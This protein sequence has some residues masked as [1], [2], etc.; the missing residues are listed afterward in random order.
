MANSYQAEIATYTFI[1][2]IDKIQ[3]ALLENADA[4]F[5]K[6]TERALYNELMSIDAKSIEKSYVYKEKY[7]HFLKW[8]NTESIA[9]KTELLS[10]FPKKSFSIIPLIIQ[11]NSTT[12]FLHEIAI[13]N[14]SLTLENFKIFRN[15]SEVKE[16]VKKAVVEDPLFAKKYF[17]S[18]NEIF[19]W[20]Q[21]IENDTI[22]TILY[23]NKQIGKN[24]KA[25]ALTDAIIEQK[26]TIEEAHEI[27]KTNNEQ[28]LKI[29]LESRAKT[30]PV[31]KFSLE[32]ELTFVALQY[33]RNFN[34]QHE[35]YNASQRFSALKTL[36]VFELYTLIVYSEE[37]IFTS[38]F[39]GVFLA[40]LSKMKTEKISGIELMEKIGYNR[41]RAFVKMC[42]G[43]GKLDDFL[44]TFKD[45]NSKNLFIVRLIN[46]IDEENDFLKEAVSLA[47]AFGSISNKKILEIFS[48]ELLKSYQESNNK[49]LY[50]LLISVFSEKAVLYKDSIL[51]IAQNYPV[52]EIN[53]LQNNTL[54]G[55]DSTHI[56]WHFFY[57]DEDGKMSFGSFLSHFKD[58]NW[59]IVFM[60]EY[61]IISSL[62]GK[63]TYL[64]AN[65]PEFE[66][67][68]PLVIKDTL[69]KW[70]KSA[71]M[72]VHRGHS[73]YVDY[74][75]ENIDENAKIVL[76]GSCGSYNRISDIL[77]QSPETHIISTRQIGT[78]HVN[79]PLIYEIAE[80]IRRGDDVVWKTLWK[81]L[82]QRFPS[83]GY[84]G[85]KFREY[86]GPHQNLGA[87]FIQAYK[88]YE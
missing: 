50:G 40:L 71:D 65:K 31:A 28:Y 32:K 61:V 51:K 9:E 49:I 19:Q 77:N 79:N 10:K 30:N 1:Y 53:A 62:K 67:T 17:F 20:L 55:T 54:L 14:P 26:I 12:N 27:S 42:S 29:M 43:Y 88:K 73:F 3:L 69:E 56:Q 76:L 60:P 80:L 7:E 64:F 57:D 44:E 6:N 70:N 35:N 5:V 37:E 21:K 68:A 74:T 13:Q 2:L 86:I 81:N 34:D 87:R 82:E 59:S 33:I 47:D 4:E 8:L 75:I 25:F 84:T 58:S 78:M 11:D 63:K 18:S 39:N 36:S 24:T 16:I 72:I 23:I 45:E 46:N 85:N 48:T 66:R 15:F 22:K 38:T 41:F 83:G 52:Q